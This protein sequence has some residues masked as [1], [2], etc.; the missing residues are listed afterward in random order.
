MMNLPQAIIELKDIPRT[1]SAARK[2][3]R[4]AKKFVPGWRS[5]GLTVGDIASLYLAKVFGIDPLRKDINDF[6]GQVPEAVRL[7]VRQV[8]YT[9]GQ[10]VRAGF[11]VEPAVVESKLQPVSTQYAKLTYSGRGKGVDFALAANYNST[12]IAAQGTT[13]TPS[14]PYGTG[15]WL[16]YSGHEGVMFGRVA[17]DFSHDYSYVEDL[18]INASPLSTAWEL[19]PFSFLADWF[20]DLGTWLKRQNA[21][22]SARKLG[23]FLE[24]GVWISHRSVTK[25]YLPRLTSTVTVMPDGGYAPIS[26]QY[27]RAFVAM[28]KRREYALFYERFSYERKRYARMFFPGV[29]Y[30]SLSDQRPFQ[31]SAGTALAI[32]SFQ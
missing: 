32:Q 25:G 1:V 24:D 11:I 28:S 27:S 21:I 31:W 15:E 12:A 18:S 16:Q 26:P 29:V 19:I 30:K 7:K 22:A 5:R 4:F 6:L 13:E 9:K 14:W 23:F 17:A 10:P 2:L 3:G 8:R 20:V